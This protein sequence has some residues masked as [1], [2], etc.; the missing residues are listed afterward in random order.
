MKNS[1]ESWQDTGFI[2]VKYEENGKE[3]MARFP[4]FRLIFDDS[5]LN[6]PLRGQQKF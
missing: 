6:C 4:K 3:M 2:W 1:T 5:C